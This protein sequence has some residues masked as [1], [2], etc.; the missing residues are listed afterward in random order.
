MPYFF[1]PLQLGFK[2]KIIFFNFIILY[3]VDY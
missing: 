1:Y 2:K 3:L